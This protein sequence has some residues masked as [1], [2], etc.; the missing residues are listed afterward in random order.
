MIN[1]NNGGPLRTFLKVPYEIAQLI[2]E[3]DAIVNLLYND[4]A[5]A[6]SKPLEEL[7]TVSN[8]IKESYIWFYA[9]AVVNVNNLNRNTF[10]VINVSNITLPNGNID[11]ESIILKGTINIVTNADHYMLD[12]GRTRLL[13]I[14]DRLVNLLDNKKLSPTGMIQLESITYDGFTADYFSYSISFSIHE[15]PTRKVEL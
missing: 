15:I 13:E 9:P 7:P 8:L 10:I 4:S 2:A 14:S 6:L 3:N 12:D 1:T 11:S 5:S